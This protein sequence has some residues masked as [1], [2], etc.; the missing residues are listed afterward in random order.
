MTTAPLLALLLAARG[1]TAPAAPLPD[2]PPPPA[3]PARGAGSPSVPAPSPHRLGEWPA[4]PSGKT[5]TLSGELTLDEALQ[6]VAEEGGWSLVTRTGRVGEHEVALRLRA[7]PVEEAVD[8]ILEGTALVATRRGHT[9]TVAPGSGPSLVISGGK[10]ALSFDVEGVDLAPRDGQA[11]DGEEE[12][13]ETGRDGAA[14]RAAQRRQDG[15]GDRVL[16]GDQVIAAGEA[17]GEV[18]VIGGSVRLESGASARQVV[19]I[20]GSIELAPGAAVD[21]EVV[22]IGGDVRVGPGATVGAGAVSVGGKVIIDQGG[23]VQGEQVSVAIPGVAALVSAVTGHRLLGDDRPPPSLAWRVGA[24]LAEFAL[25]F[26]LGLLA[27]ALVPRRLDAVAAA[28]PAQPGRAALTGVLGTL[29]I[30]VLC[31][32]LVV[33]LIGIPFLAVVALALVAATVLGFTALALRIGRALPLRAQ[34]G[35]AVLELAVG[36]ALLVAL[37]QV[38]VIGWLAWVAAWL[39]LFGVLLRTRFGQ[40]PGQG[41][42]VLDTAPPPP[43]PPPPPP[44]AGPPTV[45]PGG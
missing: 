13:P 1:A 40:Q 24:I 35:R 12:A 14:D 43:R 16:H 2:P 26:L 22:A 42:P 20:G 17:A 4:S 41:G 11:R 25:W 33:T 23:E 29:A 38:P 30:P 34:R 27:L 9:V 15:G 6:R 31:L 8:A 21:Q 18:V 44:L 45:A 32:L 7:V 10:R 36:M 39:F 3:A 5:I 19:A 28:L 37:K